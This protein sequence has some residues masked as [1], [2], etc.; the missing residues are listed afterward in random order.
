MQGSGTQTIHRG[1][2]TSWEAAGLVQIKNSSSGEGK[3]Q[4][5]YREL[6]GYN[7]QDFLPAH[8]N[9][10]KLEESRVITDFSTP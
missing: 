1:R 5:A 8:G 3:N 4:R 10:R 6:Y 9:H 2:E 7:Q